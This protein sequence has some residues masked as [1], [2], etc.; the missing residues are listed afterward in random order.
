MMEE[1]RADLLA[2]FRAEK[3]IEV[4]WHG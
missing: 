1:F 4:A 2:S 3:K